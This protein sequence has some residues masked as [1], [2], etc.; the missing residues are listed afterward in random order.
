MKNLL[1]AVFKK[2]HVRSLYSVRISDMIVK[3]RTL[4]IGILKYA[5]SVLCIA[6]FVFQVTIYNILIPKL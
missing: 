3:S 5:V 1:L 2:I 6:L 4:L